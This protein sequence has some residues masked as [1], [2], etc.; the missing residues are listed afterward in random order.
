M[1]LKLLLQLKYILL[2]YRPIN[3][4]YVNYIVLI[5]Y[6]R[7]KIDKSYGALMPSLA[8]GSGVA[9][10]IVSLITKSVLIQLQ[11]NYNHWI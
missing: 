1:I 9:R 6:I 11:R 3:S 2:I 10:N 8:D 7:H 5:R 4:V